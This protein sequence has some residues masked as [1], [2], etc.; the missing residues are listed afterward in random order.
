VGRAV[1]VAILHGTPL[2]TLRGYLLDR[3]EFTRPEHPK[4]PGENA[5]Y[6]W[7]RNT[8]PSD[9]V[10][11]DDGFRDVIMVEGRRQLLLGSSRGPEQAAFPLDQI[12][13]RRMVMAD[14]YGDADS[15][16]RDVAMLRRLARPAYVVVRPGAPTAPFEARPDLFAR[17]YAADGFTV[18][19]VR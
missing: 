8:T 18:F 7:I 17:A 19:A 12:L 13:E 10:F 5:V 3:T 15:L 2:L 6:A 4:L 1:L 11:V 16:E 14:F 9:A